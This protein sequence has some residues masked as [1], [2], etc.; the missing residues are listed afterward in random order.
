MSDAISS[1]YEQKYMVGFNVWCE[2]YG[3]HLK[4]MYKIIKTNI[5]YV[6]FCKYVFKTDKNYNI[7]IN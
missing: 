6:T 7:Y 1:A 4:I 3:K 2:K 5:N